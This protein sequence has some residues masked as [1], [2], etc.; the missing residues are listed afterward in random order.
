[1]FGRI[2]GIPWRYKINKNAHFAVLAGNLEWWNEI[3]AFMLG[4]GSTGLSEPGRAAFKN[5]YMNA[6]HIR[7]QM[8]SSL[9]RFLYNGCLIDFCNRRKR[10]N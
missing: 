6:K 8:T 1:M 10:C 3:L 9:K 2:K 5:S 7:I 4:N